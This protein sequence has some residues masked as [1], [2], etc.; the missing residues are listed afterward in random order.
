MFVAVFITQGL[1]EE[2]EGVTLDLTTFLARA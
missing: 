2:E 1:I